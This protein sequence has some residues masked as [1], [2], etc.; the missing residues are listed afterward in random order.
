MM[1]GGSFISGSAVGAIVPVIV[2]IGNK[3]FGRREGIEARLERWQQET[4]KR[5]S[6]ENADLRAAVVKCQQKDRRMMAMEMI[7]RATVPELRRLAPHNPVL[8][9]AA[10]MVRAFPVDPDM[11]ENWTDLLGDIDAADAARIAASAEDKD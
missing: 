1:P 6:D 11:P 8:G 4:V 5:L 10:A 7:V 2:W 3:L 9:Q